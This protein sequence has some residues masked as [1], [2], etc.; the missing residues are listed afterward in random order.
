MRLG[1]KQ[2][3]DP[4]LTSFAE[5]V[6]RLNTKRQDLIRPV[7]EHPREYVLMSI[8]SV[9]ARLGTDPATVL[10]IVRSLGFASYRDFKVYLHELSIATA[11]SLEGMRT[12]TQHRAGVLSQGQQSIEQDIKNLNALRNTVDLERVRNL[13]KR[14]YGARRIL[15]LAG[16]MAQSLAE[17]LEYKLLL[18]DL[19]VAAALTPGKSFHAAHAVGAK[20]LVVALSFQ[21][22]LRQTVEGLKQ[23]RTKG[24]YCVG[25]T[26][27]SV[28]PVARFSDEYFVVSVEAPFSISY[29]APIAFINLL[30]TVCANCRRGR[31]LSILKAIDREQRESLRWFGV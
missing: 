15:I 3:D 12:S 4:F 10:R 25:L 5:R 14:I 13:A 7:Q 26:N 24:A 27:T 6:A 23:A 9:S 28:S 18:L 21:R 11:T 20:D 30:V 19:P 17:A 29:A 1:R 8:R 2:H 31:T 22:G 16:D